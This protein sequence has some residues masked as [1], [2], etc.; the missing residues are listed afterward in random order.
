MRD[1]S[2]EKTNLKQNKPNFLYETHE[3]KVECAIRKLPTHWEHNK[4]YTDLY[5]VL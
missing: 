4:I 1:F 3:K 5:A 2:W